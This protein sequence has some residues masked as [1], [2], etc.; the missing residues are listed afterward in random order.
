MA[1]FLQFSLLVRKTAAVLSG[2][3]EANT[4]FVTQAAETSVFGIGYWKSIQSVQANVAHSAIHSNVTILFTNV[5]ASR[6]YNS[7]EVRLRRIQRERATLRHDLRW[8][9]GNRTC[10]GYGGGNRSRK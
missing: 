9:G 4:C 7:L 8:S 10:S 1:E 6:S 3:S 5:K 2:K